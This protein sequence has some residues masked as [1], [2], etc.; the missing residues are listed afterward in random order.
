MQ[1]NAMDD[2]PS[3]FTLHTT[4]ADE[5][6]YLISS[7]PIELEIENQFWPPT[8]RLAWPSVSGERYLLESSVDRYTSK[9]LARPG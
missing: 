4:L 1:V 8:V 5:H 6:G 3:E 2:V 9:P 7:Q